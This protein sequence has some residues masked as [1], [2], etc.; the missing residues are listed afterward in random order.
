M[1]KSLYDENNR[2]NHNGRKLDSKV[3]HAIVRIFKEFVDEGYSPREIGHIMLHSVFEMEL[4]NMIS[5]PKEKN[6]EVEQ[7]EQ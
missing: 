3:Y 2:L 4:R 1:K 5:V 6:Q 7:T